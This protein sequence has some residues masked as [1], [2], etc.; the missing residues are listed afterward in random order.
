MKARLLAHRWINTILLTIALGIVC[1]VGRN[2]VVSFPII[3]DPVPARLVVGIAVSVIALLPLY[4]SFPELDRTL[5]REPRMRLIRV[6]LAPALAV[7]AVAPAWL[8]TNTKGPWRPNAILLGLL[9]A[10][11]IVAV[12]TIG[13]LAWSVPLSLGVLSVILDA[14]P[15]QRVTRVLDGVPASVTVGVFVSTAAWYV[16]RGPH[17]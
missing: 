4:S 13:E 8:D 5:T 6:T 11:G 9:L 7:L 2:A 15:A 14:W 10:T 12:T 1:W 17:R 3:S 16:W